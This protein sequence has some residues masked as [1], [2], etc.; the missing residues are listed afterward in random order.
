MPTKLRKRIE[1]LGYRPFWLVAAR[2]E[3][4]AAQLS[5]CLV[6]RRTPTSH[7]LARLARLL[8]CEPEELIGWTDESA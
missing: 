3:M 2:A 8:E 6:G 7:Q 1:E 5:H 4:S